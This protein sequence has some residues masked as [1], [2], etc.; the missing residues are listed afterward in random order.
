MKEDAL[1]RVP[2]LS[3]IERRRAKRTDIR[4]LHTM[5]LKEN[6]RQAEPQPLIGKKEKEDRNLCI[7]VLQ[8]VRVRS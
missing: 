3:R 5:V 8:D 6:V 1:K 7:L 2:L 4:N